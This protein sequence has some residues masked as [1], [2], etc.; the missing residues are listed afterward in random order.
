ML[1]AMLEV[2]IKLLWISQIYLC[3]VNLKF[4]TKEKKK[5]RKHRHKLKNKLLNNSR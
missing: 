1:V 3:R 2:G 5:I 4:K